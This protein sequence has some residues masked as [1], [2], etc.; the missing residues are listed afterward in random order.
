MSILLSVRDAD[1]HLYSPRRT[2]VA[3]TG[4]PLLKGVTVDLQRG[5]SLAVIGKNGSGKSIFCRLAVGA[6]FPSTGSVEFYGQHRLLLALGG[7]AHGNLTVAEQVR[8]LCLWNGLRGKAIDK[9]SAKIF[10][11]SELEE[12]RRQSVS[13]LS[14]GQ[15]GRLLFSAGME[16][17]V[18]LLV[19]DESLGAGDAEFRQK[20]KHLIPE[21]LKNGGS[22]IIVS[23]NMNTL[24]TFCDRGLYMKDGIGHYYANLGQAIDHYQRDINVEL[25]GSQYDLADDDNPYAEV[26]FAEGADFDLAVLAA[27]KG[28]RVAAEESG[29]GL[30]EIKAALAGV[31]HARL[32]KRI[33]Y[34]MAVGNVNGDVKASAEK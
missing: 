24:R 2:F 25:K 6:V 5:S 29:R 8:V 19:L 18:D 22:A 34:E 26:E 14:D 16:F 10:E 11:F 7:L 21:Y 31:D 1:V 12:A 20:S 15:R 23:H 17:A 4:E 3:K 28:L 30:D 9:A 32:A 33:D 13:T 27:L